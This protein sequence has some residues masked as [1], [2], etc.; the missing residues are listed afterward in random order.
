MTLK[1]VV[2]KNKKIITLF[3]LLCLLAYL[4]WPIYHALMYKDF[5]PMLGQASI[6]LPPTQPQQSIVHD[7]QYQAVSDKA[8]KA[9]KQHRQKVK[10]PGYTAAV[11]INGKTIWSGSVGFAD[12]ER[13]V[14][15]T[16]ATQL[17][18]GSTSKAITATGLALLVQSG[19]L[20]LDAPISRYLTPLPND[21]W[22]DITTRQLAS[23]MAG[24]PHY[25]ENTEILG[26]LTTL[27]ADQHF[28]NVTNA[29]TLFDESD[30][31]FE[32]GEQFE[33]SSLG[34]V[35]L[36]AVMQGVAKQSYQSW[37]QQKVFTPL[38]M[39]QT[40]Y[41]KDD[42][43]LPNLAQFYWRDYAV[44]D[45][46]KS[47]MEVDLSHR[48]AG[49]GWVSTSND[50]VKLGQAFMNA[51]FIDESVQKAFWTVQKLN[52]GEEN[53]QGYG[54]GWRIHSLDLGD[55]FEEQLYMHH[56]GVSAGAQSFLMALPK[57][58]MSIA[59][60]ANIKTNEF[61]EFNEVSYTLAR[62]FI[63]AL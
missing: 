11:A 56:G 50:L 46:Y 12:I 28:S 20:D 30:V 53:W 15:M 41:E 24:I 39:L 25:G 16:P 45:R 2:L 44:P 47:W 22:R 19:Q 17:R 8:I 10:A 57:Y 34:T 7:R 43:C 58:K 27:K 6:T 1:D 13:N 36:S 60:N 26:L 3:V 42:H 23:H 51:S 54:I 48:L 38:N 37:M 14:P 52:N 32:P 62:L 4:F 9:L 49:G 29:L 40:T 5:A 33:Y 59:I 31:L 61:S 63:N 55:G 18:V 35:L 21:K